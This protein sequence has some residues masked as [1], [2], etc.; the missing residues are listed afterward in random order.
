MYAEDRKGQN[1][2]FFHASKRDHKWISRS[3]SLLFNHDRLFILD[4]CTLIHGAKGCD[5]EMNAKMDAH[6]EEVPHP[7]VPIK[8]WSWAGAPT[9]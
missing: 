4:K 6:T 1:Q 7:I 8:L 9:L 5:N 3:F 2:V